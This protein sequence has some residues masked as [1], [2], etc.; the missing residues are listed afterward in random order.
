MSGISDTGREDVLDR[1][2]PIRFNYKDGVVTRVGWEHDLTVAMRDA[3]LA[4]RDQTEWLKRSAEESDRRYFA[5]KEEARLDKERWDKE[6]TNDQIIAALYDTHNQ[7]E[8]YHSLIANAI[9]KVR[10]MVMNQQIEDLSTNALKKELRKR[11][12]L[13]KNR[14]PCE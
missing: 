9:E 3:G 10:Y 14:Q 7:E 12:A 1:D 5:D 13:K 2:G 11:Q 8:S 6:A 4:I